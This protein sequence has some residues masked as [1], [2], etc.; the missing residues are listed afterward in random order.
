MEADIKL[1]LENMIA[2]AEVVL[3]ESEKRLLHPPT[4]EFFRGQKII[5]EQVLAMLEGNQ[6][7]TD[8]IFHAEIVKGQIRVYNTA[9]EPVE[10]VFT[11]D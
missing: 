4:V 8:E 1:F 2:R 6:P 7:E 10:I 3:L 11:D 9:G 5:A